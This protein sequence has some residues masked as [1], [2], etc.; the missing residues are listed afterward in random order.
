M[1]CAS[2]FTIITWLGSLYLL[3]PL[4]AIFSIVLLRAGKVR[5]ALWLGSSLLVTVIVAHVIKLIFRRPRPDSPDLLVPMPSDWSF[6]SAH[7]AQATAF[8]L[9]V[10]IVA[11]R[12]L[13][14]AWAV[15]CAIVCGLIIV[16]VG[17]SRVYLQVH[18]LS[19]VVAGCALA[20][21]LV[22]VVHALL[23]Y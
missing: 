9:V 3:L 17:W 19:D 12:L 1:F 11:V 4:L 23:P 2:F 8:F 14:S 10:T 7:T 5:E 22:A 18:Y 20:I 16:C 21:I 15:I 13:P 6:P